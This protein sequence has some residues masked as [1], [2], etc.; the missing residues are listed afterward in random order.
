MVSLLDSIDQG[1]L[2]RGLVRVA[3]ESN[4]QR[5]VNLA[6]RHACIE[7]EFLRIGLSGRRYIDI[8]IE[9]RREYVDLFMRVFAGNSSRTV[10]DPPDK[11]LLR[12][13]RSKYSKNK[14]A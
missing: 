3:G 9:A 4:F 12:L 5:V 2:D 13:V 8:C 14:A 6:Y 10:P 11:F 7:A 1:R